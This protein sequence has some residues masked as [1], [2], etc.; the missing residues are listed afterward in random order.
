MK[1]SIIALVLAIACSMIGFAQSLPAG[2]PIDVKIEKIKDTTG[3]CAGIMAT[4]FP[5]AC[6]S[7][8]VSAASSDQSVIGFMFLLLYVDEIGN[9]NVLTQYSFTRQAAGSPYFATSF[10]NLPNVRTIAVLP[11]SGGTPLWITPQL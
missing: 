7:I 9:E 11:L 4:V 1:R 10:P 3:A 6:Q 5:V 8:S 2:S